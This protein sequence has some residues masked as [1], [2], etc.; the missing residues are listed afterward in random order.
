[1]DNIRVF[2]A[3][4]KKYEEGTLVGEWITLPIDFYE[5][6]EFFERIG[7]E[8][9]RCRDSIVTDY[10]T[11]LPNANFGRYPGLNDL[12]KLARMISALSWTQMEKVLAMFEVFPP[13]TLTS[14]IELV[15]SECEFT[16]LSDLHSD[17]ELGKYY[18][19]GLHLFDLLP[20]KLRKYIDY[21]AFGRDILPG[22]KR[23][24]T[25]YGCLLDI[26]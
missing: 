21:A 19:A 14:A 10:K 23:H 17:K 22:F 6:E 2:L 9:D 18:A 7:V 8:E 12:N 13:S 15:H 11:D 3:N 1:M 5:Q 26:R 16:L 20:E 24:F 25:S 4:R